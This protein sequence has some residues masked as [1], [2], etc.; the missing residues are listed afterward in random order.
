[1]NRFVY[2]DNNAT[3]KVNDE[4]QQKLMPYLNLQFGNP[5]SLYFHGKKIKDDIVVARTNVAK[6][7][8]CNKNQ[9]IFTSGGS[10][11]NCSAFNSAVNLFNKKKKIITTK[12]EHASILEYCKLLKLKGYE[13]VLLNVDSKGQIDLN[14]LENSVDNNTA[15]VSIQYANNETGIVV[16]NTKLTELI[17]KLK[18]KFNFVYHIDCVQGLGKSNINV[19]KLGCDMASF[20]GHK[21]HALKGVGCLYVKNPTEFV[22]LIAGHQENNLRG[23]TENVLG[24][25]S[26]GFSCEHIKNNLKE[27]LLKLKQTQTYLENK[28]K[29]FKGLTIN[30]VKVKRLNNTTSISFENYSGNDIMFMLEKF[31]VCVSTGSACNSESSEPSYVLTSMGLKRPQNT[32]RIS[33]DE[34]TTLSQIDYFLEKL[35]QCLKGE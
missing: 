4:I 2:L 5:S 9:V 15:I 31:G 7:I 21:L 1:M 12:V 14:Q 28:L 34:N 11:A 23:G 16:N 25:L 8:G 33:F 30:G 32:V 27:N 22:P 20:S 17:L 13:I 3:T 19:K 29:S 35:K 10:E 6:L 26:F 18:E 24:I